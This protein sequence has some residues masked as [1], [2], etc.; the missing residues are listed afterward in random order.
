MRHMPESR[1]AVAGPDRS[2]R[3]QRRGA[4]ARRAF[5]GIG[6][7]VAPALLC[8]GLMLGWEVRELASA[9]RLGNAANVQAAY[10]ACWGGL[11]FGLFVAAAWAT[12]GALAP[13][14]WIRMVG[15]LGAL[16]LTL[17]G[18]SFLAER[19]QPALQLA[20]GEQL[21][22]LTN[23]PREGQTSVLAC[24]TI[25]NDFAHRLAQMLAQ[26]P[27][28]VTDLYVNIAGGDIEAAYQAAELVRAK[29]IAVDVHRQCSSACGL[30]AFAGRRL[31][32]EEGAVV[33]VHRAS[34]KAGTGYGEQWLTDNFARKLGSLGVSNRIA[35]ALAN[36]PP[37]DLY[38]LSD[39]DLSE[40][41]PDWYD[42]SPRLP[43]EL[44]AAVSAATPAK[45]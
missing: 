45:R 34:S 40:V 43:F 10:E 33:A 35:A 2:G 4:A 26:S 14:A 3:R 44:C 36:T 16:S 20:L 17:A 28:P 7:V 41:R 29:G 11:V 21:A 39:S 25:G 42:R 9:V 15:A 37:S 1:D 31:H 32:V 18:G 23:G 19:S 12:I 38:Y 8:T 30:L 5:D 6:V 24:G 27:K 22:L 13:T